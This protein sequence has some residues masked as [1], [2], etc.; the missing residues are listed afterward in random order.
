MDLQESRLKRGM[1]GD[2]GTVTRE[3]DHVSVSLVDSIFVGSTLTEE[4]RPTLDSISNVLRHYDKT[5][6]EVA[7]YADGDAAVAK[8]RADTITNYVEGFGVRKERVKSL[9]VD[10]AGS[11]GVLITLAPLIKTP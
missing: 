3:G 6:F 11:A 7:G 4:A 8:R 2:V 10:Q 9:G 5:V 1:D